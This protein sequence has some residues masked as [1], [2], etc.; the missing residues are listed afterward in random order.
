V[1]GTGISRHVL[2]N[3]GSTK[4]PSNISHVV[5]PHDSDQ[6]SYLSLENSSA[7]ITFDTPGSVGYRACQKK[8]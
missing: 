5:M 3:F 4:L 2:T 6:M 7:P 8:F 1:P